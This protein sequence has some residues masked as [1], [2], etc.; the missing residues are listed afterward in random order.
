MNLR[1][2]VASLSGRWKA[3]LAFSLVA[4]LLLRV[5]FVEDMDTA[6]SLGPFVHLSLEVVS[7]SV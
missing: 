1:Q 6:Q 3:F 4:G 5:L 7:R 2:G